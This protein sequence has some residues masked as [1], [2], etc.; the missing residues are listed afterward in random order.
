VCPTALAEVHGAM[1]LLGKQA[2]DVNV[3]MVTVDPDRDTP[4][5]LAEYMQHFDPRFIGLTG[6][7]KEVREAATYFGVT[8]EK[9]N[10]KTSLGYLVDHTATLTLV[11]RDRRIRLVFPNGTKAAQLAE[12]IQKVLNR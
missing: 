2:N 3:V 10:E 11:D 8:F 5:V 12:D 4:A 7:V 9:R 1:K 6:S